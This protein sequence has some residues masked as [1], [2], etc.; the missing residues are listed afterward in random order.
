VGMSPG[1]PDLVRFVNAL[2][3]RMR[4]DG[5]LAASN[6]RWLS[7]TL[8]PVPVPPPARYRD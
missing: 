1:A 3:E 4:A 8:D 7:G 2:L 5:S 6:R